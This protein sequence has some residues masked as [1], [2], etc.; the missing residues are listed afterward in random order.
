[1]W[2]NLEMFLYKEYTLLILFHFL[3]PTFFVER[4]SFMFSH[5]VHVKS[6]LPQQKGNIIY[7]KQGIIKVMF[8]ENLTLE[9][10]KTS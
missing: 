3:S 8:P 7:I 2:L 1:M 9:K 6:S 10:I 4:F 5:A